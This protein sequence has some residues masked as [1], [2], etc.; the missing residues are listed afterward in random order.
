MPIT[1]EIRSLAVSRAS[2]DAIAEAALGAGMRRLRDEGYAKIRAGMTSF[3][4]L[5]RVSG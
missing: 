1:D 3:A 2:A 5:A 4:E